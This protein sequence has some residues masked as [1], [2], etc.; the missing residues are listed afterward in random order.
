[1]REFLGVGLTVL[2]LLLG[3]A[4]CARRPPTPAVTVVFLGAGSPASYECDE[5][6]FMGNLS[7]GRPQYRCSLWGKAAP[8]E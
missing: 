1:M 4:S 6:A 8:R 7:D 5:V 3:V 2:L